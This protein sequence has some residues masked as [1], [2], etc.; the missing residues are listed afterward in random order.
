MNIALCADHNF[1]MPCGVL[2][3]SICINNNSCVHFFLITDESFI[4]DDYNILK[5]IVTRHNNSNTITI[6]K[7]DAEQIKNEMRFKDGFYKV[8]ITYRLLL[9]DLIPSSISKVLYLD[10]DTIVRESLHNLW[11]TD[12]RGCA[13]AAVQDA[14][15]GKIEQ[16]NRLGYPSQLGYFNSGV[17]LI[18]LEYWRK[19]QL[20]AQFFDFIR[21][22]PES[23]VLFDQDVLNYVCR[24]NKADIPLRYNVQSDF[25][26]KTTKLYFDIWKHHDELTEARNN[27]AIIHFSGSRPWEKGT[28]HP[29]KDEFFRY[30]QDTVWHSSPMWKNRESYRTRLSRILRHSLSYFGL[31][32]KPSDPFDRSLILRD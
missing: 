21:T 16:F 11:H 18:N 10:C 32:E 9:A 25:L 17:M 27:P 19:H 13:L 30:R 31:C 28:K 14:Q 4:D 6:L 5:E 12:I 2:I 26:L 23:L 7:V 3:N 29:F 20:S 24:L 15:E 22:R 8:Q 1:L